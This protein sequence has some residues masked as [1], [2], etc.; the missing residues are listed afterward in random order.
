MMA[1]SFISDQHKIRNFIIKNHPTT[2]F[3]ASKNT[4]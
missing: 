4:D 3:L 2:T 1:S